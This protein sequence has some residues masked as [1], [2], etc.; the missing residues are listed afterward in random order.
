M[1]FIVKGQVSA[2]SPRGNFLSLP[3]QYILNELEVQVKTE[4]W[5]K[6]NAEYLQEQ[7]G[8]K[9]LREE[10]MSLSLSP[11]VPPSTLHEKKSFTF[12]VLC[13]AVLLQRKRSVYKERRIRG[14][15]KKRSLII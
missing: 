3:L 7:K 8:G 14:P 5:M 15:T 6:Q 11:S 9:A 4:L 2:D 1:P 13:W 10:V 12:C